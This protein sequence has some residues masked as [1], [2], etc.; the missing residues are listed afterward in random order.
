[1]SQEQLGVRLGLDHAEL[2]GVSH[3][4]GY[5]GQKAAEKKKERMQEGLKEE[6]Y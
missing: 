3:I 6:I 5:A 1:M 4:R 2:L